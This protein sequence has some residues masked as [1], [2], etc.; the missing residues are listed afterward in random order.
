MND[1]I[2]QVE[3]IEAGETHITKSCLPKWDEFLY[4]MQ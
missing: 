2:T 4:D 1:M 3:A